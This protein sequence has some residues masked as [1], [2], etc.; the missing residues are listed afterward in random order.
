MRTSF[1]CGLTLLCAAVAN[2]Q[3]W[4]PYSS[5]VQSKS[6]LIDVTADS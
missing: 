2:S 4:N 3:E 1:L 5:Q 6:K